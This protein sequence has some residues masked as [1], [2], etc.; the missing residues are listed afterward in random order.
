MASG[1]NNTYRTAQFSHIDG[2]ASKASAQT[3]EVVGATHAHW[4][5]KLLMAFTEVSDYGI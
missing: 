5:D 3:K 1:L 2:E 4:P